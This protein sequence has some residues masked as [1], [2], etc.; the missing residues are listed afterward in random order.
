MDKQKVQKLDLDLL[1]KMVKKTL[2]ERFDQVSVFKIDMQEEI[3]SSG[4]KILRVNVVFEGAAKDLDAE[5]LVGTVR[6]LRN[7]LDEKIHDESTLPLLSFISK[8][9]YI[10]RAH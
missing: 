3:D 8:A 5:K 7:E 4:D 6:F 10:S 2:S 1:K 9:D